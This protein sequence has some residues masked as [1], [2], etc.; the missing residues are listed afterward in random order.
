MY[1]LTV[2]QRGSRRSGDRVAALL[3]LL[4]ELP[5]RAPL[6]PVERTVGDEVQALFDDAEAVVAVALELLRLGEWSVG[7][8]VGLVDEPL[9]ESVR[10]A[11]GQAFVHA[12]TA[13]ESAKS[14]RRPVPLAVVADDTV[15]AA[16]AEA[17]LALIASVRER[18][19][20]AGWE[21]VEAVE[22]GETQ[23]AV[24]ERLGITQQA[25]SQRLRA[26][27]WAEE[28]AARPAAVRLLRRVGAD[29]QDDEP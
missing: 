6:R 14:R 13:V 10:A 18:R 26:A 24:A 23:D 1:V 27:Q 17:V 11:T 9:P 15:A 19:S 12:R 22:A 28:R 5:T 3:D 25:V 21:V 8:G 29:G 7:I 4:A 16:D 20:P 2:D